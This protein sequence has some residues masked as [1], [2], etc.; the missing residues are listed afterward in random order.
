MSPYGQL[1][2]APSA[3]WMIFTMGG[4]TASNAHEQS[5]DSQ[6]NARKNSSLAWQLQRLS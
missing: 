1:E 2:E 3:S 4:F 6:H 5:L